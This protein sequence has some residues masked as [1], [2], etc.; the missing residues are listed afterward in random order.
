MSKTVKAFIR[1]F[2]LCARRVR[3]SAKLVKFTWTHPANKTARIKAL[4]RVVH[5]QARGR[6]LHKRTLTRLGDRSWIWAHPDRYASVKAVC[7]NPP[8][9]PEMLT[10]RHCLKPGDLFV[11]VGANVGIYTIWRANSVPAL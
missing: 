5:F 2:H 11:D 6:L 4:L 1:C 3:F 9:H 7:A 10:W 8:D